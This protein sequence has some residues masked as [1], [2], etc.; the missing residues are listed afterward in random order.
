MANLMITTACN[1]RC[2]YCFGLDLFGP[3][4]QRQTMPMNLFGELLDW[5]DRA[6]MPA[7]DVH[8][9]GG[10]PTLHPG[11]GEMVEEIGRRGRK[12]VVFSNAATPIDPGLL[13]RT[14][15]L[16]ATW[17]VNC[18]PPATYRPE[19]LERLREHLALLGRT[20]VITLNLTNGSTPYAHV[21]EYI[22]QYGLQRNIKLGVALP[23]LE[24][25]NVHAE[26]KEL[27]AIA[28]QVL[29][30]LREARR[31]EIGVEF[32]C[33]VPYCLFDEE[34]HRELPG[35]H[36]SHCGSRLDI[37]PAGNIINCLPLARMAAI[38]FRRFDNYRQARE[39]F[40][41]MQAPYR[42]V[43]CASRCLACEHRL[44]GLCSACLAFGIGEYSRIAL[45]P[46][47]E[48]PADRDAGC[49][50]PGAR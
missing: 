31:R 38:P 32:E 14:V 46:L 24:N 42:Q 5:I 18:N 7:M 6:E 22:E 50:N 12:L 1:F 29:K 10:E 44:A 4:Q 21:F 19:Q 34:Q 41:R 40:H 45:P 17:I 48:Q 3:G 16:G 28:G 36:V 26:W 8:L 43:G 9:M 49:V 33:G 27:P 25:R 37:T 13:R 11:F 30:L 15:Q 35:I 2:P 23:T 39:W 20:A 47:P